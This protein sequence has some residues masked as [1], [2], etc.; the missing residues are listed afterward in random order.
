[1]RTNGVQSIPVVVLRKNFMQNAEY[2]IKSVRSNEIE[3]IN[4]D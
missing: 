1:M 3:E 4:D 2:S